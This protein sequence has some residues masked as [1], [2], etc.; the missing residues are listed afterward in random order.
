LHHYRHPSQLISDLTTCLKDPFNL[1]NN[2][3]LSSDG[4]LGLV[5]QLRQKRSLIVLDDA[6]QIFKSENFIPS[7]EDPLSSSSLLG[8]KDYHSIVETICG[9][10]HN[11]C[12]ILVGRNL[13]NYL[14]NLTGLNTP[15]RALQLRGLESS[16]IQKI[17][18]REMIV[19]DS[20][21]TFKNITEYYGG[22]PL[23]L[24]IIIQT[25]DK[26]FGGSIDD[27][28]KLSP[29]IFNPI[30]EIFDDQIKD[31]S[32]SKIE[33]LLT[34]AMQDH[35]VSFADL[36]QKISSYVSSRDLLETLFILDG[37]SFLLYKEEDFC[38]L[39]V[40]VDYVIERFNNDRKYI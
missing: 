33:V 1:R 23:I 19:K 15:D 16:Q 14:L 27:F 39:P 4:L 3:E 40:I 35:Y 20:I 17:L 18:Q 38:L 28:Q 8:Q 29:T 37:N 21:E 7:W 31:L 10:N 24:K 11:S 34:L 25:I 13:P 32:G 5:S 12:L 9:I 30:Y 6:D 22:N 36:R 2:Q 26:F